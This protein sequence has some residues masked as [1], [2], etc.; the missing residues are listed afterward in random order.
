MQG[1]QRTIARSGQGAVSEGSRDCRRLSMK[2]WNHSPICR[3]HS[4]VLIEAY[5]NFESGRPKNPRT[6]E[7]QERLL[8]A[9]K[10]LNMLEM[11]DRSSQLPSQ[12]P[13]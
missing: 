13:E 11:E 9:G 10:L 3:K 8:E 4:R 6:A 1:E 5:R 7:F 12:H 2:H